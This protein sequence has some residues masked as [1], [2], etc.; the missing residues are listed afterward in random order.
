MDVQVS[1]G[2]SVKARDL[3]R[4]LIDAG[5]VLDKRDGDHHWFRLPDGQR[6]CLPM[7]GGHSNSS[8]GIERK[9]RRALQQL[10]QSQDPSKVA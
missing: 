7:G 2:G 9:V 8:P 10:A 3:R 6:V 4:E 5:A 1:G